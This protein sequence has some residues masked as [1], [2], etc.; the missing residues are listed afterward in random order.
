[1]SFNRSRSPCINGRLQFIDGNRSRSGSREDWVS[2][3][4]VCDHHTGENVTALL[5]LLNLCLYI[6]R[7][8]QREID[9]YSVCVCVY[10]TVIIEDCFKKK[11]L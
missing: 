11:Q 2:L 10:R 4:H 5:Y 3:C 9:I 6:E 7:E 8:R 1:M